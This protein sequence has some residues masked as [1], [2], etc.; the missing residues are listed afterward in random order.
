M[1]HDDPPGSTETNRQATVG[2]PLP[3]EV[4]VQMVGLMI[5]VLLVGLIVAPV[6]DPF[7]AFR[8][9]R[10]AA[11][12]SA[13][14]LAMAGA[15]AFAAF[16]LQG[17]ERQWR[18]FWLTCSCAFVFLAFDELMQV[19]ERINSW[20]NE[21]AHQESPSAR[22]WN[23]VV[24]I[25]YGALA[26]LFCALAMPEIRRH[27]AVAV[28]LALG[29]ILFAA[30]TVIGSLVAAGGATEVLEESIKVLANTCFALAMLA[31][32]LSVVAA[33]QSQDSPTAAS[34]SAA[35]RIDLAEPSSRVRVQRA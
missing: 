9:G 3:W 18:L 15:L 20:L 13:I 16:L 32:L 22:G 26:F 8:E 7:V 25:G 11:H 17:S 1:M 35:P 34:R 19:H 21:S 31:G 12:A 27:K 24:V 29:L 2:E 23:D 14:L 6:D 4:S 5:V 33:R 28:H 30:H 10:L